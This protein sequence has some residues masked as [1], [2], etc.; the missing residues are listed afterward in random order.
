MRIKTLAALLWLVAVGVWLG[1]IAYQWRHMQPQTSAAVD[2]TFFHKANIWESYAGYRPF[3]F[4]VFLDVLVGMVLW[5]LKDAF[6]APARAAPGVGRALLAGPGLALLFVG[7]LE[8]SARHYD[9]L[10]HGDYRVDPILGWSLAPRPDVNRFGLRGPEVAEKKEANEVRIL[11]L[12]DSCT[13][14]SGTI[15]EHSWPARLQAHLQALRPALKITV[16]NGGVPGYN[17]AHGIHALR[18]Y[19]FLKPDLVIWSFTANDAYEMPYQPPEQN[20][21]PLLGLLRRSHLYYYLRVEVF[22]ARPEQPGSMFDHANVFDGAGRA[23]LCQKIAGEAGARLLLLT[24]PDADLDGK[25]VP[26]SPYMSR[27]E[28]TLRVKREVR[29]RQEAKAREMGIPTFNPIASFQ[30]KDMLGLFINDHY[31]FNEAGGD[32]LGQLLAEH[33]TRSSLL[34][35]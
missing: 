35:R 24:L 21:T 31:H 8:L 4:G 22:H 7:F 20:D 13:Y 12:G 19:L 27:D 17:S 16:L 14:G 23:A 29:D 28:I 3:L 30:Q 9:N 5:R 11:C 6:W 1:A 26:P 25:N 18:R 34:D 32:L 33:L 10:P 2:L 15:A